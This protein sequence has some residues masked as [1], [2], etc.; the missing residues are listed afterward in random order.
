[1]NSLPLLQERFSNKIPDQKP[2]VLSMH[3]T[4]AH[5]P[6]KPVKNPQPEQG[7]GQAP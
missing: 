1:M 2:I 3:D 4:R 7:H 6:G 5:D